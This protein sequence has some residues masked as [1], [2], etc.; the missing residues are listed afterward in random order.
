MNLIAITT[1]VSIFH[2]G[3]GRFPVGGA[4]CP[5]LDSLTPGQLP[6]SFS[7]VLNFKGLDTHRRKG[8][9][10]D[11]SW[12]S[13]QSKVER[14]EGQPSPFVFRIGL[15]P[16]SAVPGQTS[17]QGPHAG[18][19]V[20]GALPSCGSR[21]PEPGLGQQFWGSKQR[22]T[23][24]LPPGQQDTNRCCFG[25]VLRKAGNG[26]PAGEAPEPGPPHPGRGHSHVEWAP[27]RP[28]PRCETRRAPREPGR[29]WGAESRA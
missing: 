20:R 7:Q 22:R 10:P 2:P 8:P 4:F 24:P 29:G 6:I 14:G 13:E 23:T 27:P 9:W 28:R 17:R 1:R 18:S 16:S 26:L 21:S 3:Q 5:Q 15:G 19:Q 12:N 11:R 25:Q